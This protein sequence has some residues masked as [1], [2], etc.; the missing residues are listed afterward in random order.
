MQM[1][2]LRRRGMGSTGPFNT[3]AWVPGAWEAPIAVSQLVSTHAMD[4]P[5]QHAS[6][7]LTACMQALTANSNETFAVVMAGGAAS[8]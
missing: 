7:C 8:L 4:L 1:I 3:G 6:S 5:F 2:S